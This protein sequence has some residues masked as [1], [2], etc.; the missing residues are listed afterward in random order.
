MKLQHKKS[1]VF[2]VFL[3]SF[4]NF[5]TIAFTDSSR[6]R[7]NVNSECRPG[8]VCVGGEGQY[9]NTSVQKGCCEI[10]LP[11][12]Q[13]CLFHNLISGKF[14]RGII[15]LVVVSMGMAGIFGKLSWSWLAM[16]TISLF[17]LASTEAI[18]SFA[19]NPKEMTVSQASTK[20]KQI[21]PSG[22]IK[23]R[24][25]SDREVPE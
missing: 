3:I 7:C 6:M 25:D 8:F 23:F 18:V 16:I 9:I 5:T 2:F 1:V 21:S 17:V 19:I 14:G 11:L 20:F 15:A 22:K 4:I 12:R 10:I 13:V 24:D